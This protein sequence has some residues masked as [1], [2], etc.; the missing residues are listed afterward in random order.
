MVNEELNGQLPL[1]DLEQDEQAPPR[2]PET[3]DVSQ[4]RERTPDPASYDVPPTTRTMINM[5][6]RGRVIE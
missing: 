6:T 1:F 2:E 5:H 3:T 4:Q